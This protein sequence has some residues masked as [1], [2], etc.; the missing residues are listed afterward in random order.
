MSR[1]AIAS[2]FT[3][4]ALGFGLF[5]QVI[6][7]M[8]RLTDS[9]PILSQKTVG[10]MSELGQAQDDFSRTCDCYKKGRLSTDYDGQSCEGLANESALDAATARRKQAASQLDPSLPMA[11]VLGVYTKTHST[12]QCSGTSWQ[13][14][15][16]INPSISPTYDP[17]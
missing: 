8:E 9:Y 14:T 10:L 3:V 7:N 2:L 12:W 6:A 4:V 11:I 1:L 15:F 17:A 13:S 5:G 16:N